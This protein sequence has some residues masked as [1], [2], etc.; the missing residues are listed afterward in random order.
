MKKL[1]PLFVFLIL[2]VGCSDQRQKI[3]PKENIDQ[4]ISNEALAIEKGVSLSLAQWR[5][6]AVSDI[7]YDLSFTISENILEPISA[8]EILTFS[9]SDLS[10][11]LQLDFREQT[12]NLRKII[13]N[14]VEQKIV[15]C[16]E[17]IIISKEPLAK[18]INKIIIDF[19]AGE[20]SLN[21]KEQ[22]LYT[23]FV[24]DRAR[25]AFPVFD[26]P[27][28]KA[29]YRLMLDLPASWKALA[30]APLETMEKT[31]A[32]RLRHHFQLSD[33][34]SSYLFSFVAGEFELVQ[35]EI[36]GREMS[37]LHRESDQEKVVRNI[38]KIFAL[39]ADAI[40]WLET[41]T[42][43]NYP[44]QK[45]A[46][47]A[48]PAFQYGGM[49][50][51]GAIQYRASSL[52]LDKDPS[53]SQQL[54]RANVIAHETAH[55]WFGDLVTMD[56][57][58]DVW[59]KE[60]F[61]NFIAAK[62]V[63]PS[64][65]DIDHDLNFLLRLYPAAYSVD[66][67]TGANPI[68]Q[69]L[70]NLNEAGTLYGAIIYNKAPIMMRQLE[71]LL[72]ENELREGL[73]E[74]LKVFTNSNATW[75][76]LIEI[77]D[78]RSDQDLKAWSKVWVNMSGRPVFRFDTSKDESLL[79]QQYDASA[80]NRYWP[81]QFSVA[82]REQLSQAFDV[83]FED[84]K[85]VELNMDDAESLIINAD[86]KGYGLFPTSL[87][88]IKTLW[89][90]LSALQ[91]GA[92]IVNLYEQML[93]ND[94]AI[95]PADYIDNLLWVLEHETNELLLDASIRQIQS[96]YWS[97]L[98]QTER[99]ARADELE[100]ALWQGVTKDVYGASTKKIFLGA[101]QNI[102]VSP[103]GVDRLYSLWGGD[104]TLN[105]IS[106]SERE[107][108]A[109]AEVLAIKKPEAAP[110]IIAEQLKRFKNPDNLRR[111]EFIAPALSSSEQVRD[112]FF[113]SLSYEDN[114]A[115][116]S[117]VLAALGYLHHPLRTNQSVKYIQPSL[118]LLTEIQ[119][120]GDIFF[121]ARWTTQTLGTHKTEQ[122]ADI[123]R[124]FLEAHPNYNAQLRLKILQSADPLFRAVKIQNEN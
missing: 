68:R 9:L 83:S 103:K 39:H 80:T 100:Q 19:N 106:L 43:I 23:L 107:V 90:E 78:A 102:A 54:A 35:R 12:Q 6:G 41:Y 47:A 112:N 4:E 46:F 1:V 25:T 44:F 22:Y 92:L 84:H 56:W 94:P 79:L 97:Y 11:D 91:K 62:V 14:D 87:N 10:Q 76:D 7:V 3:S 122:A 45:F 86:G 93:E 85:A 77:L 66:R 53:Q 67:T 109:L 120:T 24:P 111:F 34:I 42:G 71:L 121:P 81:Q 5:A 30:N 20:S 75:P 50:H 116:E 118:E 72:G 49:E 28:L 69:A 82:P 114:R 74:Y 18:G 16:N 15:H 38:E 61:A 73:R 88:L 29:R 21:R 27:N 64:F 119:A 37:F 105:G 70:P 59:T 33:L 26:Q 8:R 96:I 31:Q 98:S 108:A 2:C 13:V 95:S 17:H 36:N 65:P 60:V 58:N 55:M 51:V 32:G 110:Q 89:H 99:V 57:F 117:W 52:F 124:E 115:T 123:V 48:I 40:T 113:S 104:L 63:N 101:F